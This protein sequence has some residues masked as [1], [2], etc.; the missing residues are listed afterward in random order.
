MTSLVYGGE[1]A[2]ELQAPRGLFEWE[3]ALRPLPDS[4]V[5]DSLLAVVVEANTGVVR[6][7]TP[8]L[9][10]VPTVED[11]AMQAIQAP[12]GDLHPARPRAFLMESG[13]SA[14]E[15]EAAT[16][17]PVRVV[18]RLPGTDRVLSDYGEGEE[19]SQASPSGLL[20]DEAGV[21]SAA[22]ALAGWEPWRYLNT[23]GPITLNW[24][25]GPT[26][27]AVVLPGLG[28][29]AGLALFDD[30]EEWQAWASLLADVEEEEEA[31]PIAMMPDARVALFLPACEVPPDVRAY[32]ISQ[33]LPVAHGLYPT[34]LRCRPEDPLPGPIE[35]VEEIRELKQALVVM[36]RFFEEHLDLL[37]DLEEA[38][39][40]VY[41][42]DEGR[43]VDV[44]LTLPEV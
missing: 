3:L 29:T 38:L 20:H 16:G 40:G 6:V 41:A 30:L 4:P 44:T 21:M 14:P 42:D 2:G 7:M 23:E 35:D 25:D 26:R 28:G 37:P 11:I 27:V 19:H 32:F 33:P 13:K 43:R 36:T 10:G 9:C 39:H 8:V 18:S 1:S 31:D 22:A 24:L 5:Q 15:V 17:V 34:F 12:E